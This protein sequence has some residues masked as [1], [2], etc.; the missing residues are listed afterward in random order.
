MG[1]IN[2]TRI[3]DYNQVITPAI[4]VDG[5]Y[6]DNGILY[7]INSNGASYSLISATANIFGSGASGQQAYWISPS[8]LGYRPSNYSFVGAT[9]TGSPSLTI[10]HTFSYEGGSFQKNDNLIW[11]ITA[12]KLENVVGTYGVTASLYI[13][14]TPDLTGSPQLILNRYM[15]PVR[16]YMNLIR[17]IWIDSGTQSWCYPNVISPPNEDWDESSIIW[18]SLN[19]DWTQKQYFIITTAGGDLNTIHVST[20]LVV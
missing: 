14:T 9:H 8:V 20:K 4:G 11:Q 7:V 13:N 15:G 16:T 12:V 17:N 2:I 18:Q 10:A 3:Q 5:I 6:N 1:Q 19:I